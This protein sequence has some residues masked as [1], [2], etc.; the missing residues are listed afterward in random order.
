MC[1]FYPIELKHA[2]PHPCDCRRTLFVTFD[3]CHIIKNV[4]SQFIDRKFNI[5]GSHVDF[6]FIRRLFH[7][8]A[9]ELLQPVRSLKYAT[10]NPNNLQRQNV[11]LAL[12]VF[13]PEIIAA[14]KSRR[15]NGEY[16]G[17]NIVSIQLDSI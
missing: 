15:F 2:I 16:S 5:C 13:S 3:Y 6:G 11:Q 9:N 1:L 8:Q 7:D 17:A 10:I 12:N 4:R 14:L